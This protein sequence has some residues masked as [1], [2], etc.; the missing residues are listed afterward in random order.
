MPA[1]LSDTEINEFRSRLCAEAK[2]QFAEHGVEAVTMRSLTKALG[3]SAT[4]PYRYFRNKEEI[5]AAVRASILHRVCDKLE[6]A[7]RDQPNG[8]AW[9]RAHTKAFLDFAFHEPN[10]YRLLYDLYQPEG[11][12][13]PEMVRATARSSH[14]MT[15]Y[16]ERL[17]EEGYVQGN[18]ATLGYHYFA[19]VHG[20]IGLHMTG[21]F[22]N[23]RKELDA[24]CRELLRLITAGARVRTSAPAPFLE[25]TE[26]FNG[27]P[28][29]KTRLGV[30]PSSKKSRSDPVDRLPVPASA[31]PRKKA[32]AAV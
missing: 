10:A 26:G 19:A 1:T 6:A 14:L 2:R 7:G 12:K 5:L 4:T 17:I 11:S 30:A 31:R 16:V 25:P 18:A 21:L 15:G 27:P 8:V 13:V 32:S 3:C 20:L 22:P 23:T 29:K 24:S 9:A 28:A